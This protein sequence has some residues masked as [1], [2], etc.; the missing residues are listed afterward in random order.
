MSAKTVE[1]KE[2]KMVQVFA[3]WKRKSKAGNDFFTGKDEN[4]INLVGF[5]NTKKQNPKEPDLRVYV[6][7]E[8]GKASKDEF[9]SLWCNV[10]ANGN[11]Y[12]T[13]KLGEKRVVGFIRKNDNEKAPYVSVYYSEDKPK[14]EAPKQET[15][16]NE[17]LPF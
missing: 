14:E 17:D 13:G 1:K 12:L 10:S 3:L 6:Q 9:I 15:I 11:K 7:G 5:F 16:E 4:G 2:F 8:D